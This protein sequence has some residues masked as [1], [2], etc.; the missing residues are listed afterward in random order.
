RDTL[1]WVF[2]HEL[3]H[4]SRGDSWTALGLWLGEV[5][6][7]HLPWFWW[8][9]RQV[10]LCQEYVADA[11]AVGAGER[12][13][14]YAEFLV[15]LSSTAAVPHGSTGVR[16]TPTDLMRRV[17]RLLKNP[18]RQLS[19]RA[20]WSARLAAAALLTTAVGAAGV[21]LRAADTSKNEP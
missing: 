17:T 18:M 11:A 5:V 2:A 4:L 8:I 10:R 12:A 15:G 21:G 3:T 16:G 1:K 6:Y 14:D 20:R 7:Y 19:R 9:R 13:A